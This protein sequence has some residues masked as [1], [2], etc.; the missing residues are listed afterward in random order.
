M[1]K[2]VTVPRG[3]WEKLNWNRTG[4]AIANEL[5]VSY[6][7]VMRWARRLGFRDRMIPDPRGPKSKVDWSKVDFDQSPKELAAALNVSVRWLKRVE[8]RMGETD[9]KKQR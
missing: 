3:E 1:K 7:T 2:A 8:Q 6:P 5:G 4:Q 9:G